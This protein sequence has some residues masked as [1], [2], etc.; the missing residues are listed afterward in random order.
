MWRDT[1]QV[2]VHLWF[3]IF[4]GQ[5][6]VFDGVCLLLYSSGINE[7]RGATDLKGKT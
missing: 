3:T 4:E 2:A 5:F 6:T 7:L 1:G